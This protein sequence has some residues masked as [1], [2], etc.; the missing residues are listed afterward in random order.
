[1]VRHVKIN[2][3]ELLT[4]LAPALT[5]VELGLASEKTS[6]QNKLKMKEHKRLVLKWLYASFMVEGGDSQPQR[7]TRGNIAEIKQQLDDIRERKEAMRVIVEKP[8][9]SYKQ[10]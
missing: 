4:I 3:E 6:P 9:S 2:V 5:A 7:I 8:P 10:N 1:M